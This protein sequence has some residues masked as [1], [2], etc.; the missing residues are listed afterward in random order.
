MTFR[1]R[2]RRALSALMIAGSVLAVVAAAALWGGIETAMTPA[3]QRM[4]GWLGGTWTVCGRN[5]VLV[6]AFAAPSATS[7]AP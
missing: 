5:I 1:D 7:S 4:A 6:S 3:D 2:R